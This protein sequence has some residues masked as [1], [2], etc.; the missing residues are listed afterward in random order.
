MVRPD[1]D[2]LDYLKDSQAGMFSGGEDDGEDKIVDLIVEQRMNSA[3]TNG[4]EGPEK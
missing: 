2:Y 1:T 4:G 3:G